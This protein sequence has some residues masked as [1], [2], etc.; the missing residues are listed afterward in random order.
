MPH[1]VM[2]KAEEQAAEKPTSELR[3]LKGQRKS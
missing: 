1:I 2:T 3:I